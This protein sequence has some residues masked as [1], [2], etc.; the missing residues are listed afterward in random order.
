MR[1][2][3]R[4]YFLDLDNFKKVND[5]LGHSAG[6][7]LLVSAAERMRRTL[8]DTDTLARIGGDEFAFLFPLVEDRAEVEA[9]AP[10][11]WKRSPRRSSSRDGNSPFQGVWGSASFRRTAA[12]RRHS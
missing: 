2:K 4:G 12:M 7:M 11:F 9:V 1:E 10:G 6:D 8:R 5:A 3:N